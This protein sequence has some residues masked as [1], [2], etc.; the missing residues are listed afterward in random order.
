MESYSRRQFLSAGA[1]AIAGLAVGGTLTA[2]GNNG[3]TAGRVQFSLDA[4]TDQIAALKKVISA[5][6]AQHKGADIQLQYSSNG[7]YDKLAT[8]VAS[9][10]PPDLIYLTAS[11]IAD[12]AQRGVLLPLDDYVPKTISVA[13]YD[14]TLLGAGGGTINGKL[15]ALPLTQGTNPAVYYD[16]TL[17]DKIGVSLPAEG[18]TL[19]DFKQI[20]LQIADKLGKNHWGSQDV[21]G[22]DWS[23]EMFVRG[24]GHNLYD[25]RTGRIA[26][27]REDLAD[28]IAFW[29]DLRD[30]GAIPPA[31]VTATVSAQ[32]NGTSLV[33]QQK[34]PIGFLSTSGKFGDEQGLTHDKLKFFPYPKNDASAPE[35]NY[36]AAGSMVAVGAKS[37]EK[38]EACQF[39]NFMINDKTAIKDI[40]FTRGMPASK[41]ALD[42]LESAGAVSAVDQQQVDYVNLVARTQN[43][44]AQY[45]RPYPAGAGELTNTLLPS[46]YED[47]SFGKKSLNAVVDAFFSEAK[48]LK[49]T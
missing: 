25:S 43:L 31:D 32:S 20:C 5:Y 10:T 39:L 11:Y 6:R 1:V 17:L 7:Y 30:S 47:H 40:G 4:T 8:R 38:D 42:Q 26:F 3:E 19:A 21:G 45:P 35:S 41:A 28:H 27:T 34:A 16:A 22:K 48:K 23:L 14:K 18:W 44:D 15:Y 29:D 49:L 24:R 46:L 13:G 2:C 37:K 9:G 36:V 12:Y 33:V